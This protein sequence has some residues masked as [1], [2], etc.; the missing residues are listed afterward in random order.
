MRIPTLAAALILSAALAACGPGDQE[1]DDPAPEH[2]R[3]VLQAMVDAHEGS[4]YRTLTFVQQ[5]VTLGPDGVA[6]D[7]STWYEALAPGRLR[8]D[9]A[10][11]EDGNGVLYRDGLRYTIRGGQPVD[12]VEDTNPLALILS[13]AFHRPVE[14]TAAA[15]EELGFDL[16]AVRQDRWEGEPAWVVGAPAGDTLSP[17]FWIERERWLPVR[18]VSRLGEG[19]PLMDARIGGYTRIDGS[20]VESEIDIRVDGRLAQTETYRRVRVDPD[21]PEDLFD[22]YG[23]TLDEPYWE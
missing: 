16:G 14:R 3:D 8:I 18:V 1:A 12:S 21:L 15:L 19:G 9:V 11:L 17:Q 23:W 4:R 2:G 13:D 22:P 6:T 20:W 5:T 10:P 7:T